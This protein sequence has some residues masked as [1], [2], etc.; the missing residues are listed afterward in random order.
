MAG[1]RGVDEGGARGHRDRG[2]QAQ[3]LVAESL[4]EGNAVDVRGHGGPCGIADAGQMREDVAA[5]AGLQVRVPAQ[6]IDGPGEGGG[7]GLVAGEEEGHE[8]VDE[9]VVGDMA[10]AERDGEDVDAGRL[11]GLA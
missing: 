6:E 5:Q 4:Q 7:D 8:V 2:P 11:V 3:G 10:G 9:V 1:N